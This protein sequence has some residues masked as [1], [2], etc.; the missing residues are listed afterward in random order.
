[1]DAAA[2]RRGFASAGLQRIGAKLN[3]GRTFRTQGFQGGIGRTTAVAGR[4]RE[5][6]AMTLLES[7]VATPAAKALGWTL[8]YSLFEGAIAALV[9][10]VV[11]WA[12]RPARIRYAAACVAILVL[13]AGF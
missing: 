5:G 6:N 11:L 2:T 8:F 4:I 3:A 9:L 13:L 12:I 1:M 10:A 7:W